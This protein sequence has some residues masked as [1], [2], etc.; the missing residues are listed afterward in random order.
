[1]ADKVTKICMDMYRKLEKST[2]LN[3]MKRLQVPYILEIIHIIYNEN[4]SR[5]IYINAGIDFFVC[6]IC[7]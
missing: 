4:M 1:M 3:I 6:I 2:V 5:N 7:P